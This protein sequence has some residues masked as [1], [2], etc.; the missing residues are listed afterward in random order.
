LLAG[1]GCADLADR[2]FAVLSLG[3]QQKILIARALMPRPRLLI[4]DEPC[5]G[6]DIG[7]RENLLETI[8]ALA[9]R[10]RALTLVFVTHHIEEI[11]PCFTHVLAMKAGE[12]QAAGRKKDVLTAAVLSRTFGLPIAVDVAHGR[13][14]PRVRGGLD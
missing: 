12:A 6:L 13:Y 4:L 9:R 3:E 1:M 5:A 8:H 14:W 10:S 7:G 2:P 11:L